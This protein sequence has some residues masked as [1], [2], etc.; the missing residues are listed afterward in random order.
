MT[1][2]IPKTPDHTEVPLFVEEA[3][4]LLPKKLDGQSPTTNQLRLVEV[5][6]HNWGSFHGLHTAKIDPAGTL[7]TGDNGAGK[8][9]F[10]DGI[11]AL[12]MPAGKAVFNV[13]A[14]QGDKSDRSLVS[15]IRGS[16]GSDHDGDRTKAR[17]KRKSSVV[18]GLRTLFQWGDGSY[19]TLTALF[20]TLGSSSSWS[21]FKRVYLVAKRDLSLKELLDRFGDG[22]KVRDF[23]AWL[24]DEPSITSC[25]ENF[26]DYQELYRKIFR[27]DNKNAPALL[28]RA[29][30]LKKID[31]LTK[32]IQELVLEPCTIRDEAREAVKEFGDLVA[33]HEKL[34]DAQ[35]QC[36]HL[37][38]LPTLAD[39][40]Q[41]YTTK[42]TDLAQEKAH[43]SSFMAKAAISVGQNI[44]GDI[45]AGLQGLYRRIDT[46]ATQEDDA[47][48]LTE[49]RHSEY[50]KLGGNQIEAVKKDLAFQQDKLAATISQSSSYQEDCRSL[51]LT[52]ELTQVA[53]D[54]G[55]KQASEAKTAIKSR[56][57]QRQNQF[58][59]TAAERS[60]KHKE[61]NE[62]QNTIKEIKSRP[63][64]NIDSRYQT[65]RDDLIES[66]NI[67]KDDL[68]FIGEIIDVKPE[69]KS[70]Q[71]AIERAL[72]GLRTTLLVPQEV[73]PMV[74]AWLNT[75]HTKLHVRAQVV[76]RMR[77]NAETPV[78]IPKGFL[79]K[80]T[81]KNHTY[82][83]WL[84]HHLSRHD[85]RCVAGTDE[86][87]RTPFSMTKEGLMHLKKGR[88]DKKDQQR[89]DDR[90]YWSLGF[91]NKE[92]LALLIEDEKK[93]TAELAKIH[94]MVE[95]ARA[96]WDSIQQESV[97]WDK[98]GSYQWNDINAPFWQDKVEATKAHLAQLQDPG[99]DLAKALKVWEQAKEQLKAIQRAKEQLIEQKGSLEQDKATLEGRLDQLAIV[100]SLEIPEST[101]TRLAERV[102]EVPFDHDNRKNE[103]NKQVDSEL[104]RL[105][106]AKANRIGTALQTMSGFRGKDKWQPLTVD[107]ATGIEGLSDYIGYYRDLEQEGLPRL[108][109]DFKERLTKNTTQSLAQIH[110]NL[111]ARREEIYLRIDR[112]N[113]ALQRTEF[114]EGSYLKLSIKKL[115]PSHVKDFEQ[116]LRQCLHLVTSEDH[117]SRYQLIK[118]VIDIIDK[119][120]A[121][122]SWSTKESLQLLDPRYQV[123]FAAE[124]LDAKTQKVKEVLASST[125][126]SGGEKESF[127]GVILAASLSYVLTPDG[128]D[129]PVF[130]T[131]FLDEALSNTDEAA[132]RRV[133][134]VFKQLK[135]SL[136]IIT[137]YKNLNLAREAARS[138][139]IVERDPDQHESRLC[140]IT[141][142][143]LDRRHNA[144]MLEELAPDIM[145]DIEVDRLI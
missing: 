75:R 103:L 110:N 100:A 49:Q 12:L 107:W 94:S 29:L 111:E 56:I 105:R 60:K 2:K 116:R 132:S 55:Q 102:G 145:A 98:L 136:N 11:M 26:S 47:E 140:E 31:D 123:T 65:L 142:E 3:E 19:V 6:V 130:S 108:A 128:E 10:V 80:L 112:I 35:E 50:L 46:T 78:F 48:A 64:S 86:L 119:A 13:A 28:T 99:H 59:E 16:Y 122:A 41:E 39:E 137:P 20:W 43:L 5:S 104:G 125:D 33:T 4:S 73:F 7:I 44:L 90:R 52:G 87:D 63:D 93:I 79:A 91:S 133:L 45:D 57:E 36:E 67:A 1:R 51:G 84:K 61:L 21:D 97:L 30:G 37:E 18:T 134:R 121:T 88:F 82:S 76:E 126:K 143:E 70:W 81:W 135:L 141:W 118:A 9:T 40:I 54:V 131:V 68:A 69:E 77:H 144:Q 23:K 38:G 27:M 92:R 24:K 72:G 85:L 120:S 114:R 95:E 8:S 66:L 138:L 113:D 53:F 71:G 14:A 22:Q 42:E 96:N 129:A 89:I 15:Y 101:Y 117:E 25:N 74:T 115:N 17:N 127:A 106:G 58:G 139:L 109:A 32:M 124:E 62:L 83:L 34:K